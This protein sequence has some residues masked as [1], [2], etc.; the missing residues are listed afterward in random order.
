[1]ATITRY[2]GSITEAHGR[3][4]GFHACECT[5]CR[6]AD[7]FHSETHGWSCSCMD[8]R[9]SVTVRADSGRVVTLDHARRASSI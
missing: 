8:P 9:L 3:V 6:Q 5:P 1:M 2:Q 4:L 7:R